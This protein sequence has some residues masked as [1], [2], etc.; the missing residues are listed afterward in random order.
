VIKQGDGNEPERDVRRRK[1]E[2]ERERRVERDRESYE[3]ERWREGSGGE[4]IQT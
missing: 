1:R 4:K 2:G 3:R